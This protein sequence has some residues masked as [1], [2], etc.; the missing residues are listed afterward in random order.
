MLSELDMAVYRTVHD[1]PG[2]AK[3]LA[4]Y[5]SVRPGTLSNKA[6]PACD[7]HHL[8]L[9]EALAI[10]LVSKDFRIL[11]ALGMSTNHGLVQLIDMSGT[12]D[13][14]LLD[15]Y[16]K[17]NKQQGDMAG[18]IN[19]AF[20]DRRLTLAEFQGIRHEGYQVINALLELL[21]RLEAVID[22]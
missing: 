18:A 16:S 2:G 15:A 1:F 6:D 8:N 21:R 20:A 17:M 3:A 13:M 12:S 14:E 10:M 5:L 7:T 11:H 22:D 9:S 19:A 4:T